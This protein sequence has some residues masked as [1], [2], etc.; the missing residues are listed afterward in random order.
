MK[1]ILL[2]VLAAGASLLALSAHAGQDA[3]Q[4][5]FKGELTAQTCAV[6]VDGD[7]AQPAIVTL[8]TIN[9]NLL[10]AP[11]STAANRSFA[12]NLKGC[13]EQGGK[14]LAFFE[15]NA[16]FVDF[17]DGTLKN[18]LPSVAGNATLVNLRLKDGATGNPIVVGSGAQLTTTTAQTV[19][20]DGSATLPYSVEYISPLGGAT[21]GKVKG[22]VT[23]SIAYN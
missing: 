18:V 12:I 10:S 15:Y 17:T 14:A 13:T 22:S 9:A 21:A 2:P 3:G 4:I 1:R 11:G 20:A 19:A 16:A 23:Y 6:D 7:A 5:D 8:P